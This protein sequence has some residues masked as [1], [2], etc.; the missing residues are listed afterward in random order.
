M[1]RVIPGS[2]G[3]LPSSSLAGAPTPTPG[4]KGIGGLYEP[5][6]SSTPHISCKGAANLIATILL[7]YSLGLD[8]QATAIESAVRKRS[9]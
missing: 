7:C 3:L 8:A 4:P 5:I 1:R 2:L 6:H 9:R